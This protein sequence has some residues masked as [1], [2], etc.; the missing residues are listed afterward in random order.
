VLAAD[1]AAERRRLYELRPRA[2]DG[3]D[4]QRIA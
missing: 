3:D 2:D 1:G 4:L